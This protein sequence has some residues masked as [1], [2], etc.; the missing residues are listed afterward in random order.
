MGA[1]ETYP[2]QLYKGTIIGTETVVHGTAFMTKNHKTGELVHV[3]LHH[4]ENWN[5][6]ISRVNPDTVEL[7]GA[8]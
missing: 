1:D 8:T 5:L 4:D 2:Y 7:E 3:I 6:T